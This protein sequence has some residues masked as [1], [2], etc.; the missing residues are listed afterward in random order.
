MTQAQQALNKHGL[1][2]TDDRGMIHARPEIAIERDSR[3]AFLRAIRQLDIKTAE[4]PRPRN[5]GGFGVT[6]HGLL[7]DGQ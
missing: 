4:Q 1:T 5:P 3:T 6:W 2:Y 7:R